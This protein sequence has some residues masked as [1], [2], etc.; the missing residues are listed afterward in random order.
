VCCGGITI[1]VNHVLATL[2]YSQKVSLSNGY[3]GCLEQGGT[4]PLH[5]EV[6]YLSA[7]DYEDFVD[8]LNDIAE[9]GDRC[10]GCHM[11]EFNPQGFCGADSQF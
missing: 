8:A 2:G 10:P 3:W 5:N 11:G 6:S 4:L 1:A 9:D 7:I